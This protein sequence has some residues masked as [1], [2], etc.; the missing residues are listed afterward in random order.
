MAYEQIHQKIRRVVAGKIRNQFLAKPLSGNITTLNHAK[1]AYAE[2]YRLYIA[3]FEK[4]C[5][6]LPILVRL[7]ASA[8][9]ILLSCLCQPFLSE[10]LREFAALSMRQTL[11]HSQKGAAS[12]NTLWEARHMEELKEYLDEDDDDDKSSF[13]SCI[14]LA[15]NANLVSP[16][17]MEKLADIEMAEA[18]I[19]ALQND[20]YDCTA[21]AAWV[22][23]ELLSQGI[24]PDR[25]ERFLIS[26][27]T[28]ANDTQ[29]HI[30]VAVDRKKDSDPKDISTWHCD[31]I[32]PW[33]DYC[34]PSSGICNND[35]LKKYFLLRDLNNKT[36][37]TPTYSE[38][39]LTAYITKAN[40]ELAV[41]HRIGSFKKLK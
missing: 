22:V 35:G 6:L 24:A 32:D 5:L 16:N 27:N 34:G 28:G 8:A 2:Q 23:F 9:S 12:M 15:I 39:M 4:I 40:R 11:A 18:L 33:Y 31:I 26:Y 36:P 25:I 20:V 37:Q 19:L 41:E 30:F 7:P 38:E 17:L 29:A 10:H 1:A 13:I 21:I 14:L 3:D